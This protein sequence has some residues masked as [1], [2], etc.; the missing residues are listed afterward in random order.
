[1]KSQLDV[2]VPDKFLKFFS[3]ISD[4]KIVF[5]NDKYEMIYR[6]INFTALGE[7]YCLITNRFDLTTYQV[8]ML[9]AYRWQVEL[10]FRFL[11]RTLKA[12]HLFAQNE[13]GI[14][15]QLYLYMIGYLLLLSFKQESIE[16]SDAHHGATIDKAQSKAEPEQESTV[17]NHRSSQRLYVQG[18]VSLLG[19]KLK[20]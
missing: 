15:I 17:S 5:N 6:I 18:L 20:S 19:S 2:V 11:K 1:I 14:Q 3:D 8:I 16:V 7:S 4:A 9:Y 12:I 13:N 10:C